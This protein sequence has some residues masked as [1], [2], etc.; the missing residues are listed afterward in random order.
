MLEAKKSTLPLVDV[1]DDLKSGLDTIFVNLVGLDTLDVSLAREAQDVE[2]VFACEGDQF[3]TIRPVH[4]FKLAHG[5]EAA[6]QET[7][8]SRLDLNASDQTTGLPVK[9]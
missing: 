4:L 6:R 3:A 7:N 8:L 9:E 5:L 1:R 2:G